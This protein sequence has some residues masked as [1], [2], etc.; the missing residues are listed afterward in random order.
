[1]KLV[2]IDS[3]LLRQAWVERVQQA[4]GVRLP[5]DY[6]ARGQVIALV[7][8]GR[9]R[10]GFS[11]IH[12]GPFRSLVQ[13]PDADR[14]RIDVRLLRC[15]RVVECNGLFLDREVRAADVMGAF[16]KQLAQE[17]VRVR[18]SHLVFSYPTRAEALGKLY[19]V[20]S[21][22]RLYDGPVAML[23]GMSKADVERVEL[24]TVSRALEIVAASQWWNRPRSRLEKAA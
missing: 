3:S 2:R 17:L 14:A 4:V 22:E 1:M 9:V 7:E 23:E 21:P 6:L 18:A 24:G 10:G 15:A 11:V 19:Q 5:D 8:E 20:L 12:T 13:I 16:W